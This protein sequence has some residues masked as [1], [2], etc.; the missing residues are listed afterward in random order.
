MTTGPTPEQINEIEK[1]ARKHH[2]A[3]SKSN[4]ETAWQDAERKGMDK[5]REYCRKHEIPTLGEH[6]VSASSMINPL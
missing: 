6:M 1:I 4:R 3:A 2:R 5:V